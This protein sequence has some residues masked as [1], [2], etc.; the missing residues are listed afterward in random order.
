MPYGRVLVVDDVESN[1]FV[2]KGLLLPYGITVETVM[3]GM[4]AI[5]KV[6]LGK[7]YDIIFMDHMMPELDGIETAKIIRE[8][9]YVE[10][11]IA[12]TANTILGQA[13]LFIANGFVGFISKPIDVARL[14]GYLMTFVRDKQPPE[15]LEA[16]KKSTPSSMDDV[17]GAVRESF[18]RDASRAIDVIEGLMKTEEW[19]EYEYKLYTINTHGMKSALANVGKAQLSGIAGSLEQA[20]NDKLI[21]VIRKDTDIF[22]QDLREVVKGMTREEAEPSNAVEDKKLLRKK[23]VIIKEAC[24]SY[25]KKMARTAIEELKEHAWKKET[26]AL[27]DSISTNLLH[28]EFEA[29]CE[30]IA[31]F[32]D[33]D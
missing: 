32:M 26:K 23:L 11:I 27:L 18:L 21:T 4:E 5:E 10:P 33:E 20:G 22:I 12:L 9:G 17:S 8:F 3:S 31:C 24:D 6:K 13:E 28:S 29:I 2:A 7:I 19:G 16:A 25:N 14:N 15:V 1:L 30:D